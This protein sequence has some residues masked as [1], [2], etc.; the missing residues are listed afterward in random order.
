MFQY[1]D[2]KRICRCIP[3][4]TSDFRDYFVAIP[5]LL[6]YLNYASDVS[7]KFR[8]GLFSNIS[9]FSIQDDFR[10][11]IWNLEEAGITY[12]NQTRKT[13]EKSINVANDSGKIRNPLFISYFRL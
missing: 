10:K 5:W 13:N 12:L 11:T 1:K 2:Y 7:E 3:C 6:H 9:F 4:P 8:I